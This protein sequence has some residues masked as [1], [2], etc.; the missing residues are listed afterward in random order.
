[1]KAMSE[2][3]EEFFDIPETIVELDKIDAST[4]LIRFSFRDVDRFMEP[5]T[6]N[7]TINNDRANKFLDALI[8][9]EYRVP[10]IFHIIPH[11]G[12]YMIIDGAHRARAIHKYIEK[13]D[14]DMRCDKSVWCVLYDIPNA[15]SSS[16][17]IK[18][19]KTINDNY[20]IDSNEL[21]DDFMMDLVESICSH[22]ILKNGIVTNNNQERS[23]RPRMHK[24]QIRDLLV[25][26]RELIQNMTI[27][28]IVSSM[29]MINHRLSMRSSHQLIGRN[30]KNQLMLE[31]A[32]RLKFFLNLPNTPPEEWIRWI[33]SPESI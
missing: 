15:E 12:R 33:G 24:K 25:K 9:N 27:D 26:N 6:F 22:H 2:T 8:N 18:I 4:R 21:P 29:Q 17:T 19:F 10:W 30:N 16:E 31:K 7:R 1:M 14:I 13:H 20:I 32:I 23:N 3:E 11:N 5:W 28:S